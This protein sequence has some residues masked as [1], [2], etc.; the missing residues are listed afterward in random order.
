MDERNFFDK[1]APT[2][3]ANEVLSTP[4]RVRHVL[5]LTGIK[6]DDRV[7]DLGTGTGVL[8]PYI[9]EIVGDKGH[10]TAVDYSEGMLSRAITKFSD[11]VPAPE[12]IKCDFENETLPG[13]YDH[14][15]LYCVYP[16]LHTPADTLKWFRAVNLAE[17]G[18]M[19]IAFPSDERF[20]NSIHREKHSHSDSLPPAPV[21]AK[22]LR[23]C[24]LDAVVA[25]ASENYY[26]INISSKRIE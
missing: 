1:L 23:D 24:G 13:T 3:D 17:G 16:H 4:E 2:W 12:F 15:M 6:K 9:A 8:L 14:I 7:L 19:T 11:I 10:I 21:L 22:Y 26:V 20:I 18:T 5:S 25:E